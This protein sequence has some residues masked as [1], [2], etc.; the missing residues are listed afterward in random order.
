MSGVICVFVL[1]VAAAEVAVGMAR[2][3]H[4]IAAGLA[5]RGPLRRLLR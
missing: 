3:C 5:P 1:T 4:A 2:S